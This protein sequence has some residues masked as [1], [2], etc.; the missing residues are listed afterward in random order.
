M[1]IINAAGIKATVLTEEV[2]NSVDESVVVQ[3]DDIRQAIVNVPEQHYTPRFF[4]VAGGALSA[5]L[6]LADNTF[7]PTIRLDHVP[8]AGLYQAISFECTSLSDI[9]PTI[10]VYWTTTGVSNSVVYATCSSSAPSA[11]NWVPPKR[12]YT[13][14]VINTIAFTPG[15]NYTEALIGGDFGSVGSLTANNLN[16]F[17]VNLSGGPSILSGGLNFGPVGRV[18]TN[19]PT[20]STYYGGVSGIRFNGEVTCILPVSVAPGQEYICYGGSFTGV[21]LYNSQTV[22]SC[23][24]LFIVD[25]NNPLGKNVRFDLYNYSTNN[26]TIPLC[27]DY[28]SEYKT[29]F[30][31]GTAWRKVAGEEWYSSIRMYGDSIIA[32]NSVPVFGINLNYNLTAVDLWK[33]FKYIYLNPEIDTYK[34]DCVVKAIKYFDGALYIGGNFS[35]R[36][37][38]S[39]ANFEV[40]GRGT[41]GTWASIP[42][43]GN[44]YSCVW[45][46]V[47]PGN[48]KGFQAGSGGYA[49]NSIKIQQI[50][51]KTVLYVCGNFTNTIADTWFGT[52]GSGP[53]APYMA[54][55]DITKSLSS[56]SAGAKE[57]PT[58]L[59]A[60]NPIFDKPVV[61]LDYNEEDQSLYI[62]GGFTKVTAVV[63]GQKVVQPASR[64][65]ILS[66]PDLDNNTPPIVH[67][68][69]INIAGGAFSY[70]DT[71]KVIPSQSPL[72]GV[73]IATNM[74]AI[75]LAP[76]K[77]IARLP[78]K[79]RS[80]SPAVAK[81]I[82][83]NISSKVVNVGD[84][85]AV[86]TTQFNAVTAYPGEN[87]QLQ[88]LIYNAPLEPG[89]G[90]LMRFYIQRTNDQNPNQLSASRVWITGIKVSH[91]Q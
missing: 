23:A 41:D 85:I 59:S 91:E 5:D 51:E 42:Y 53:E 14:P 57:F 17:T 26:K 29:L 61:D 13:V 11:F 8:G 28:S 71:V 30:V 4:G 55:Y 22:L 32:Q 47:I 52:W 79:D 73:L 27:L 34:K 81:H 10:T 38:A 48:R 89:V 86:D 78:R 20:T 40:I 76:A 75:N 58:Y 31:G 74:N 65:V 60:W 19:T 87:Y 43:A 62:I 67:K 16:Y 39:T 3:S 2:A 44:Q 80:I 36:N 54:A 56:Y 6:F 1:A 7:I 45:P 50:G 88:K 12:T 35:R 37:E 9:P 66:Q 15:T 64:F 33:K 84:S 18:L 82:Q 72:S 21:Q 90:D 70:S 46:Y 49:V 24:G 83:W 25:K 77:V 68:P 69:Y 63:E